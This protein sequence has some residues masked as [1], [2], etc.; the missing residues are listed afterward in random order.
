MGCQISIT[1]PEPG[2]FTIARQHID[3]VSAVVYEAPSRKR[4]GKSRQGIHHR[5]QIWRNVKTIEREI[6]G[7]VEPKPGIPPSAGHVEKII[8]LIKKER[9]EAILTTNY[10]G[11]KEVRFLSQ[12]TKVKF[13][14]LPHDVG[15]TPACKD[16]FS[17]MDQ[18][19]EALP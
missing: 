14:V 15:A 10:L 1:Q 17:L 3:H 13:I 9:P 8:E 2:L 4:V 11:E 5:I 12:K 16:W 19:L 7:Y 18:V 6:I